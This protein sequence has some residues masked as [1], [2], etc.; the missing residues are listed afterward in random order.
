MLDQNGF[1]IMPLINTLISKR[2]TLHFTGANFKFPDDTIIKPN[3]T[4]SVW[5]GKKTHSSV[6][7][8][9]AAGSLYWHSNTA[10]TNDFTDVVDLVD[11]KGT[12]FATVTANKKRYLK[13][14]TGN[15]PLKPIFQTGTPHHDHFL[16]F[17][18]FLSLKCDEFGEPIMGHQEPFNVEKDEDLDSNVAFSS[19]GKLNCLSNSASSRSSSSFNATA[20]SIT[21]QPRLSAS[22]SSPSPSSTDSK[23]QP[24]SEN[25][26]IK[27]FPN[28]PTLSHPTSSKLNICVPNLKP[29]L[30]SRCQGCLSFTQVLRRPLRGVAISIINQDEN[31]IDLSGWRLIAMGNPTQEFFLP[32]GLKISG[33]GGLKSVLTF[34]SDTDDE[35]LLWA[36]LTGVTEGTATKNSIKERKHCLE[37][38]CDESSQIVIVEGLGALSQGDILSLH[39]LDFKGRNICMIQSM[40]QSNS[41]GQ[42]G[43]ELEPELGNQDG[44]EKT[45]FGD[46][47]SDNSVSAEHKQGGWMHSLSTLYP[48]SKTPLTQ[49]PSNGCSIS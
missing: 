47:F 8:A 9:K 25:T 41:N 10:I 3:S 4:L 14:A 26:D 39:L 6:R 27:A 49:S 48:L 20:L 30:F 40:I 33:Q 16:R 13:H 7:Q 15:S 43:L 46:N 28:S 18:H 21:K 38:E 2:P 5:Y 24:S 34:I 23:I 1:T 22:S 17:D 42:S 36:Q 12:V 32:L 19:N 37:E 44:D 31:T 11:K 29:Y 45:V 35:T